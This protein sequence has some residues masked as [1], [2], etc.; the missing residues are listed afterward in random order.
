VRLGRHADARATLERAL[1]LLE[2]ARGPKHRALVE[3]LLGLGE[4]ALAEGE[5]R[6]AL[7]PLERAVLLDGDADYRAEVE[8]AL[9]EALWALG[10]DRPRARSL[11]DEARATFARLGNTSGRER[12]ER[13][14][15]AHA[16][17]PG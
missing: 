12:G 13:W 4:L 9:A 1:A 11:A 5:P 17:S 15:E 10:E 7:T 14:L 6:R 2:K 8:L 16:L 3:P